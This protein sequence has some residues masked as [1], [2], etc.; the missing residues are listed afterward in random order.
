MTTPSVERTNLIRQYADLANEAFIAG[1]MKAFNAVVQATR[2][3]FPETILDDQ[4]DEEFD[5]GP[6]CAICGWVAGEHNMD[7]NGQDHGFTTTYQKNLTERIAKLEVDVDTA[8]LKALETG[9]WGRH[10]DLS[11]DL[12]D[13]RYRLAQENANPEPGSYEYNMIEFHN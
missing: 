13:L 1:D 3:Q 8:E 6:G 5:G 10:Q 11:A 12:H 2:N 7:G 4:E 9:H